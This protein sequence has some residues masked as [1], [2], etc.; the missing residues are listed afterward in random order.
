VSIVTGGPAAIHTGGPAAIHPPPTPASRP[1]TTVEELVWLSGSPGEPIVVGLVAVLDSRLRLAVVRDA[2]AD[3]LATHPMARARLHPARSAGARWQ[4]PAAPDID[5]VSLITPSAGAAGEA[6]E[7]AYARLCAVPPSLDLSPPLRVGLLRLPDT[8]AIGIVA[9][10]AVLD[11]A[12]LVTLLRDLLTRCPPDPA[13]EQFAGGS[14]DQLAEITART[15][16]KSLPGTARLPGPARR[17]VPVTGD[18]GA[19]HRIAV[20]SVPIGALRGAGAGRTVNDVLVT[21]VHLALERWNA[22]AGRPTGRVSVRMPVDLRSA[23]QAGVLGNLTG[24]A[25]V[26]T[27]ASDRVTPAAALAAVARQ[28]A[29]V[30]A[31]GP[32]RE[33]GEA[34]GMLRVLPHRARLRAV[35]LAIT[36]ARPVLMPAATLSNLGPLGGPRTAG[37]AGVTAVYFVP[38][39]PMP[40]G[41]AIGAAGYGDRVEIVVS[42]QRRLFDR[43]AA[44]RFLAMLV[45]AARDVAG[46][47]VASGEGMAG[48]MAAGEVTGG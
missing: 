24:Q 3:L 14:G 18:P 9:H 16:S 30:K 2:V 10:H 35:R 42:Y 23:G 12:S 47:D 7:E 15:S 5:P 21:A 45:A 38:F 46:G 32:P 6:L 17:A 11:G 31:V 8:D 34:L 36:L 28:T 26:T 41:L 39:A 37:G 19:G 40:Q 13:G 1:L 27:T 43:P 33:Q 48:G 20:V 29:A 25:A 22:A 4:F 44:R